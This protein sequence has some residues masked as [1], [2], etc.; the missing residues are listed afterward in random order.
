[1]PIAEIRVRDYRAFSDSG[2]VTLGAVTPI[3]GRNDAGKSGLLQAL[4]LFYDPPKKVS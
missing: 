4:R 3:V 1:M 2:T